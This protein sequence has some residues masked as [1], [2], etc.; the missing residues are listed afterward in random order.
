[1]DIHDPD[2]LE[3][4]DFIAKCFAHPADLSVQTLGQR[5]VE[6]EFRK[7]N[8]FC[9]QCLRPKN[10]DTLRHLLNEFRGDWPVH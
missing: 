5:N 9:W 3:S 4:V 6:I 8:D 10:P 2:A 1:M 7:L